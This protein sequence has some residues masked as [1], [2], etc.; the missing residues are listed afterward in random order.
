[1]VALVDFDVFGEASGQFLEEFSV[2][3]DDDETLLL[4]SLHLL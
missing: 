1:M 3:L 4:F 2:F